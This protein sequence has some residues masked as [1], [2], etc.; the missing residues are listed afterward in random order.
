MG[1][2]P[3]DDQAKVTF[4]ALDPDGTQA[5]S[6]NR[7]IS[8]EAETDDKSSTQYFSVPEIDNAVIS[9]IECSL[10][11]YSSSNP[12]LIY[13]YSVNRLNTSKIRSDRTYTIHTIPADSIRINPGKDI[14]Y[15][16]FDGNPAGIFLS[17]D[18]EQFFD[19]GFIDDLQP[20]TEYTLYYKQGVDGAVY[21]KQFRTASVDYG[22][23]I[24]NVTITDLNT[25]NLERD[26]WQY[27]PSEHILTLRSFSC[28]SA[29][30]VAKLEKFFGY[31]VIYDII[32][33]RRKPIR[34]ACR[35]SHRTPERTFNKFIYYMRLTAQICMNL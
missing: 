27:D 1:W 15:A 16:G 35:R 8:H 3:A 7:Y 30:T 10:G 2:S 34:P 13:K 9:D 31:E 12:Q 23:A 32:T 19:G 26:G 6:V 22:V 14:V 21:S 5:Y 33:S 28:E 18:G 11:D 29:G 4:N 24:G 25:G 17:I 20:D